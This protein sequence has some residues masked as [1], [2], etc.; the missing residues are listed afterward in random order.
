MNGFIPFP[1]GHL[2][3]QSFHK[4]WN[5]DFIYDL[6]PRLKKKNVRGGECFIAQLSEGQKDC[7]DSPMDKSSI[8]LSAAEEDLGQE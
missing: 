4:E 7:E 2:W 6:N 1:K 8:I 3:Y 5:G